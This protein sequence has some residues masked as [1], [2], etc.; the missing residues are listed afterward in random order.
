MYLVKD[1]SVNARQLSSFFVM[2]IKK[3]LVSASFVRKIKYI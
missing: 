2:G 3:P 1:V